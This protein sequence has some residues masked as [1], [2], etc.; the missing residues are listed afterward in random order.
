MSTAI[1]AA[2]S[3]AATTDAANCK[4]YDHYHQLDRDY[5]TCNN[6]LKS[7]GLSSEER[8]MLLFGRGETAY[9][10]GRFDIAIADL[11]ESI[12]LNPNF[13][14][15]YLR[16]GWT[17]NHL[18]EYSGALQDFSNFLEMEPDN[19]SALF[20]IGFIYMGSSSWQTKTLPA[21]NRALEIDPNNYLT[22]FN[23]ADIYSKRNGR[24]D[25]AVV[26]YDRILK[27]SDEEVSKVKMWRTPGR[28]GYFFKNRVR[29]VRVLALIDS[30]NLGVAMEALNGLIVDQPEIPDPYVTRAYLNLN[31]HKYN[32]VLT[33][34][35]VV[36][37]LDP[38]I[39]EYKQQKLEALFYLKR[40]DEGVKSANVFLDGGLSNE[41]KGFVL[42]WRGIFYKNLNNPEQALIDLENS[43]ILT[44]QNQMSI[45]SRLIDRGYYTG[46]YNDA[47]SEKVRNGL[48][49]CLIDPEC[50]T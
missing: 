25:L 12:S 40:Y 14:E 27:A 22:R 36:R 50:A 7:E 28:N 38:F 30:G 11:N 48:Q 13:G 46:S 44:P 15:A 39:E 32:E 35:E 17:R 10:A 29:Y 42:F 5:L 9:F 33:D 23:L 4:A 37:R 34:A 43:F 1:F 3:A 18:G 31:Q 16:R 47:Y 45:I 20:A 41:S 19:P 26:E 24:P 2:N 49:A 21:F 6:A 8:A